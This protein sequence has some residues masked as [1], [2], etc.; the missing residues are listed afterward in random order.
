MKK[1]VMIAGLASLALSA[2]SYAGVK[3]IGTTGGTASSIV[4]LAVPSVDGVVYTE[5]AF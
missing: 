5:A 4:D 3:Y 2:A 1:K